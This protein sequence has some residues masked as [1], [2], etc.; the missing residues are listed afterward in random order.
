MKK[1]IVIFAACFAFIAC[2]KE[3]KLKQEES[4]PRI[5]IN[6]LFSAGD[7]IKVHLSES[8]N[9]LYEGQLPNITNATINL[10]NE[11]ETVIGTFT[12]ILDGIYYTT[13]VF[14]V[15]GNK[16]GI[17]A[18]APGFNAIKAFS[19]TPSVISISS[20]DTTT[21]VPNNKIE[22]EIKFADDGSQKN[23][24]SVSIV[25]N[26]I[27]TDIE[28]GES[29]TSKSP[30]FSTKEFYVIN[31]ESDVD[32]SK[33]GTEFLFSDESFN[34]GTISFTG[35]QYQGEWIESGSFFVVGVKSVSEDLFKYK[36]SY[37]KYLDAQYNIFAEPVQ[38]YSNVEN[39]FGIF[40][41][42][43]VVTDTIFME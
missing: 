28:T 25:L 7:T 32:G 19:E 40:G 15:A 23:Y 36:V 30:Y 5:V 6:S 22:F 18:S 9:I 11:N 14:P 43:S 24:Y 17:T 1:Y 12:H 10:I 13:D 16:Y 31:G 34:G 4:D 26:N 38:V 29:D 41:G 27:W 35:S 39:G 37:S 42:S 33:F 8:R 3:I 21:A 20:I 2:E